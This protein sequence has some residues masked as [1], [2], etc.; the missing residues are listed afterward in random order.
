MT[1]RKAARLLVPMLGLLGLEATGSARGRQ[2][3]VPPF[4]QEVGEAW[5]RAGFTWGWMWPDRA[6]VMFSY[7]FEEGAVELVPAFKV[8]EGAWKLGMTNRLPQP[9]ASFGLDLA[10]VTD[11]D[12][13]E[14]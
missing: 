10:E 14:L 1:L 13:R 3:P 9:P 2:E 6:L 4:A 11:A 5:D 8:R 7:F 12:L